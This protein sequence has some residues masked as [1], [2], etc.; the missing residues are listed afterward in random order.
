MNMHLCVYAYMNLCTLYV[1]KCICPILL[2]RPALVDQQEEQA[3]GLAPSF[4][5]SAAS[6]KN[7]IPET[8]TK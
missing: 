3:L 2:P 7:D 8:N 6:L 4:Q 1:Y 5:A